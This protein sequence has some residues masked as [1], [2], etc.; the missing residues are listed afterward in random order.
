MIKS[1]TPFDSSKLASILALDEKLS[2]WWNTV[3]PSFKLTKSSIG[4]IGKKPLPK[5]VLLNILYHQS[6]CALH[7][8]I[9]PLFSWDGD[10]DNWHAAR[11]LSAQIAFEHASTASSI[12]E[13]VVSTCPKLDSMPS[14][15]SYAAYSGCAIQIPFMWCSSTK[16]QTAARTFVSANIRL[17]H[18]MGAY[19]KLASLLV[20]LGALGSPTK[21]TK[22]Y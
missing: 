14:F 19:W 9:V 22:K 2:T 10:E 7:A 8:S 12:I 13:A 17:I 3:H 15:L 6:L 16:V 4:G 18:A 20:S 5:V 1:A 11:H 21:L